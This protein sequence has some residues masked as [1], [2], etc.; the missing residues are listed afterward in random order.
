ML[1]GHCL[2]G[3]TRY[4][5]DGTPFH[6]SNCHCSM[7]RRAAGA[8]FVTW[9][10][11]RRSDLRWTAAEPAAYRS[12]D[13]ATRRFCATCGTTLTFEDDRMPDEL[14]LTTCSLD[15][16]AALPPQDQLETDARVPWVSL[17]PG[18]P[19]FPRTRSG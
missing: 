8:P 4:E 18:L 16:P 6:Q 11:V 10:S 9:F 12:S 7:C 5:A 3:A 19:V 14:D 17:E 1:T 13:H 2:C 15:D